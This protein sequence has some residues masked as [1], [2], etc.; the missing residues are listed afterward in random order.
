M[1]SVITRRRMILGSGL[2]TTAAFIELTRT[3][4][5]RKGWEHVKKREGEINDA[6]YDTRPDRLVEIANSNNNFAMEYLAAR[7]DAPSQA[8]IIISKSNDTFALTQLIKNVS[9]PA[10]ALENV[11][12]SNSL[13]NDSKVYE[14]AVHKNTGPKT[15]DEIA[16]MDYDE[17]NHVLDSILFAKVAIAKR[18]DAMPETLDHLAK[19][20]VDE[21]RKAVVSNPQLPKSELLELTDDKNKE[22]RDAA[23]L[24]YAKRYIFNRN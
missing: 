5:L 16:K 8:L 13:S 3:G 22:I 24:F 2:L 15:L 10:E 9:S 17:S 7:Q 4:L 19:S 20:L 1:D 21:I 6:Q 11:L 12:M 18:E 23:M 14:I